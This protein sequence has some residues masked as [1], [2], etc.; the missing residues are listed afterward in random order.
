MVGVWYEVVSSSARLAGNGIANIED[1]RVPIPIPIILLLLPNGEMVSAAE[2][3]DDSP[4]GESVTSNAS[5]KD[6]NGD[7]DDGNVI[8]YEEEAAAVGGTDATVERVTVMGG[9]EDGGGAATTY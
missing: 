6:E 1:D 7:G 2:L 4:D 9:T 3:D 5:I 8:E